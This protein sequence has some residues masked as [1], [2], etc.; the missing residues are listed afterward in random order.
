M[1]SILLTTALLSLDGLLYARTPSDVAL[2]VLIFLMIASAL[3]AMIFGR[4]SNTEEIPF[5][6]ASVNA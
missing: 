4:Y 1:T 2:I 6:V 5:N 3:V